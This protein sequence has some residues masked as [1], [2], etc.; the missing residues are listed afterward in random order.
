MDSAKKAI[1]PVAAGTFAM[2]SLCVVGVELVM[3]AIYRHHSV[4]PLVFLGASRI[5]EGALM[6]GAAFAGQD[7][8]WI[9]GISGET[10][11]AGMGRGLRWAAGFAMVLPVVY[12][13]LFISGIDPTGFIITTLPAKTVRLLLFFLVGGILSPITEE[14]FFRGFLYGFLR[15]WGTL[16]AVVTSS[17][18]FALVHVAFAGSFLVPV[19][20]GL[21]LAVCYEVEKNLMAPITLHMVGNLTI[22]GISLLIR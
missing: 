3:W 2:V 13:A 12:A 11:F 20:G 15:R 8:L 5:I 17:L 7:R 18:I 4:L 1:T 16:P 10:I 14:L 21:I 6:L 9:L 19:A 22:F